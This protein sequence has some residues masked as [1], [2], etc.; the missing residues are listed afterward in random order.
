M[1]VNHNLGGNIEEPWVKPKLSHG[2][3]MVLPRHG[4]SSK[5]KRDRSLISFQDVP[6]KETNLLL[7]LNHKLV[8]HNL[9]DNQIR[10][11]GKDL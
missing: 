9:I 4:L 7:D 1:L 10:L 11:N 8:A 2:L 3:V 5:N 6:I